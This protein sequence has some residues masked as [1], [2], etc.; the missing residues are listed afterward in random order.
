MR[1]LFVCT[2]NI[3]RSPYAELLARHLAGP[4]SGLEFG[5]A[6]TRALGG[7][8]IEAHMA[9]ELAARGVGFEEFRST[10]LTPALVEDADLVLTA[11][12]AHRLRVLEDTPSALRKAFSLGQF[13]RGLAQVEAGPAVVDRVLVRAATARPEEDVADPY[14]RGEAAARATAAQLEGLLARLLPALAQR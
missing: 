8:P 6:G 7:E 3:C 9:A 5:S 10:R 1:V 14:G 11:E 12:A 2:A 4:D 13:T